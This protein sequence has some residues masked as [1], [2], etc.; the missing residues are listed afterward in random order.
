MKKSFYFQFRE[1]LQPPELKL[2]YQKEAIE[3][4]TARIKNF[5]KYERKIRHHESINPRWDFFLRLRIPSAWMKEFSHISQPR[6]PCNYLVNR[7]LRRGEYPNCLKYIRFLLVNRLKYFMWSMRITKSR[8]GFRNKLIGAGIPWKTGF[9]R[10]KLWNASEAWIFGT[11]S[12]LEHFGIIN[13][14]LLR[15]FNWMNE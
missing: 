4:P 9:F 14:F 12:S 11:D 15:M 5:F 13:G 10:D 1:I 6:P 8:I 7:P 3:H 2:N